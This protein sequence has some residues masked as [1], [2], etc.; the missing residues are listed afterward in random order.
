MRKLRNDQ[1]GNH[2]EH[3]R[4]S[5]LRGHERRAQTAAAQAARGAAGFVH[6]LDEVRRHRLTDRTEAAQQCGRDD[7][8]G[9]EQ[10]DRR[11]DRRS[12]RVRG[13]SE[14]ASATSA[15]TIHCADVSPSTPPATASSK[16]STIHRAREIARGR[17]E[18]EP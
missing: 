3:D 4:E 11:I 18:R 2:Q 1:R 10:R 14:G 9:G 5:D 6:R 12:L 8:D 7:H 16:V 13:T 17:A 15:R